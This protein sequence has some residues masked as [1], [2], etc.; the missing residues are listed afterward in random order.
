MYPDS[1]AKYIYFIKFMH[2]IWW[3]LISKELYIVRPIKETTCIK[4]I[5]V[6]PTE[7]LYSMIVTSS[8]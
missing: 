5:L 2:I 4:I 3:H 8:S 6:E 7:V 1:M